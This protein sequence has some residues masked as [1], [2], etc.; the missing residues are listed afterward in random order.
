MSGIDDFAG[1]SWLH[2]LKL[3]SDTIVI[4]YILEY[5]L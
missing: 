4:L 5:Q 1:E 3:V 2:L